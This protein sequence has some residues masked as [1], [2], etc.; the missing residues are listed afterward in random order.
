MKWKRM[1]KLALAAAL[2]STTVAL[3][4]PLSPVRAEMKDVSSLKPVFLASGTDHMLVLLS[5]GTVRAWGVNYTGQLGIGS[6]QSFNFAMPVYQ[7]VGGKTSLLSDVTALAAGAQFS[8]ALKKDGTVWTWGADLNEELGRDTDGYWSTYAEKVEGLPEIAQISSGDAHSLALAKDGTVWA[9]GFNFNGMVGDGTSGNMNYAKLPVQVKTA[10]NTYLTDIKKV[11]AGQFHSLALTKTGRVMAWGANQNRQLGDGTGTSR[12][13]PVDVTVNDGSPLDHVTQLAAAGYH[14]LAVKDDGTLWSWGYNSTGELGLGHYNMQSR[15]QPVLDENGGPFGDVTA[16]GAGLLHSAA[17]RGDGCL[18]TWGGNTD[19]Y[20]DLKYQLGRDQNASNSPVPKPVLE[21]EDGVSRVEGFVQVV[22]G[23]MHT[24]VLK[25]DGSI[26]AVGGNNFNQI[27]GNRSEEALPKLSQITLANLSGTYWTGG[28][29]GSS[30]IGE[31]AEVTL[32][33]ADYWGNPVTVGT[34]TV[35]MVADGPGVLGP[36]TYTGD[37]KFT[38]ELEPY[39][40]GSVTVS[41]KINGLAVPGKLAWDITS[42][43][44]AAE[45]SSLIAAPS[46][47]IADGS[48]SVKLKLELRDRFGNALTRSG[49]AVSFDASLGDVGPVT[50]TSFGVYEAE[51]ASR[52]TGASTVQAVLNGQPFGLEAKVKFTAGSPDSAHSI[53][54]ADVTRLPADG[55]SVATVTLQVYDALGNAL[56]ESGGALVFESDLGQL[57]TVTEGVYGIYTA[58]LSSSTSGLATVTALKEG[59]LMA[60]PLVI[61]FTPLLVGLEFGATSYEVVAGRTVQSEVKATYSNGDVVPVT[62]D[63]VLTVTDPALATINASGLVTGVSPGSTVI[64]AA[65]EGI[66]ATADLKVQAAP[67]DP[68]TGSEPGTNPGTGINPGPGTGT[69]PSSGSGPGVVP[70]QNAGPDTPE[71]GVGP[72]SGGSGPGTGEPGA[73]GGPEDGPPS[74]G[75]VF[76]DTA[77]HWAEADI[78]RA[79][80]EGLVTGYPDRTFRPDAGVTRA[81]FAALLVRLLG[82]GDDA[83]AA[84][85][86][87]ALA[88]ASPAAAAADRQAWP[89]WASGAISLAMEAGLIEGYEDGTFRPHQQITRSET[90]VFLARAWL[91][92]PGR[93]PVAISADAD[94]LLPYGDRE[95]VLP[96]AAEAYRQLVAEELLIGDDRALLRPKA[97]LTRAEAVTMLLRF[98]LRID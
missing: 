93:Q 7:Q 83:G 30:P 88:L 34:D 17:L 57:S 39:G 95:A 27:G 31:K 47:A 97:Q 98:K 29:T 80:R 64:R 15:A 19:I 42:A 54:S 74:A 33:L 44:P 9:W 82:L 14:S 40:L 69:N 11:Q 94:P 59:A 18:W 46:T 62:R 5:D 6:T 43:A 45:K 1:F 26:W 77:G 37:G 56:T 78:G 84:T 79:V 87:S 51:L 67:P 32:Q 16:I 36:V 20:G 53:L 55:N 12:S 35:E 58:S 68:G 21:T 81:E 76:T 13:Y 71:T 70:G 10:A 92:V 89:A 22:A 66:S 85:A 73:A 8:V 2:F 61:E 24:S 86:T 63:S 52:R 49:G 4:A 28:A 41:A 60:K 65:Y 23:S 3:M 75:S 91:A 38:V 48:S 50:E 25:T 72:G 90:A 96:W